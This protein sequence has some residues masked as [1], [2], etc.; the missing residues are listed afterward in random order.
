MTTTRSSSAETL[1]EKIAG[2]S[3]PDQLR[4]AASLMDS[5]RGDMA[6][7]VLH[8]VH[9]ELGAALA[10]ARAATGSSG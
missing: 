9:D 2:L 4:L 7:A 5:G 3:P 1:L 6:Y 10:L 8:R